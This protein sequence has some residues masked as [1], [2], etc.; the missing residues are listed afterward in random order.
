[1]IGPGI[2]VYSEFVSHFHQ[3][4][5]I[6]IE[7]YFTHL[8]SIPSVLLLGFVHKP[9]LHVS[10]GHYEYPVTDLLLIFRR[11]SLTPAKVSNMLIIQYNWSFQ[12]H[13][14]TVFNSKNFRF[15]PPCTQRF[16]KMHWTPLAS[17]VPGILATFWNGFCAISSWFR[18]MLHQVS[19]IYSIS[20]S[21]AR[22]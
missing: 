15:R 4:F 1:M 21:N 13:L 8:C 7:F 19:R 20:W 12:A 6:K 9:R 16:R 3:L 22:C 5:D 18:R 2:S 17:T 11:A 10:R 14:N